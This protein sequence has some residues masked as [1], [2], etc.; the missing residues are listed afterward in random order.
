MRL[1]RLL[2]LAPLALAVLPACTPKQ[3]I[4][5]DCVPRDVVVYV[6]GRRL[7]EL[8]EDIK[9]RSDEHHK[10][11]FKGGGFENQ[12]VVLRTEQVEGKHRLSPADLCAQA[13]FVEMRPDVKVE[14]TP[15]VSDGPR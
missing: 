8:P 14:A 11:Y 9:L 5:L 13:R 10:L 2:V 6:D 7:D 1:K 12:L 15:E 4:A 3:K